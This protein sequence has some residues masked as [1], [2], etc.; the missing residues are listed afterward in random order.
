MPVQVR[1][2]A[3]NK[4]PNQKWGGFFVLCRQICDD[5]F[6]YIEIVL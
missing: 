5:Y 1:P 2:S 6:I 4:N 3:P